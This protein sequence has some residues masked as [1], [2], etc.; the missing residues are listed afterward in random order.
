M[1]NKRD[2]MVLLEISRSLFQ[3]FYFNFLSL[4]LSV[5]NFDVNTVKE[6][7]WRKNYKKKWENLMNIV[8]L[9]S[10]REMVRHHVYPKRI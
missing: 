8:Q 3:N 4:F 1:H 9:V 7:L 10:K 5:D 2:V 6:N